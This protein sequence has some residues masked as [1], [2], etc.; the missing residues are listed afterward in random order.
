M[1]PSAGCTRSSV[2]PLSRTSEGSGWEYGIRLAE[3]KTLVARWRGGY[4]WRHHEALSAWVPHFSSALCLTVIAAFERE[5][6]TRVAWMN[7]DEREIYDILR[8]NIAVLAFHGDFLTEFLISRILNSIVGTA[9]AGRLRKMLGLPTVEN[10]G[11]KCPQ[12]ASHLSGLILTEDEI[13]KLKVKEI[14]E[15]LDKH[16]TL[17]SPGM[18]VIPRNYRLKNKPSKLRALRIA[19]A[20]HLRS[21][22]QGSDMGDSDTLVP[23]S[24]RHST[25]M[26]DLAFDELQPDTADVGMEVMVVS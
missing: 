13:S 14:H 17:W 22:H 19:V 10:I 18:T 16:R 26:L 6:S 25:K 21:M 2:S 11:T 20:E 7:V 5:E 15:Q 9:V 23:G 4:N 24:R 1:L 12:T 3:V 8:S